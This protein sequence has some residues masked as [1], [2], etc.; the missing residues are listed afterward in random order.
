MSPSFY[1]KKKLE[2]DHDTKNLH[3]IFRPNE[4]KTLEIWKK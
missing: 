2:I 1:K 3:K 4:K